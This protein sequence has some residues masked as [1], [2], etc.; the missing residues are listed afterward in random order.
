MSCVGVSAAVA[1]AVARFDSGLVGAAAATAVASPTPDIVLT[2]V[3]DNV[4]HCSTVCIRQHSASR[5]STAAA[6]AETSPTP[7]IDL[8]A[9][10][11]QQRR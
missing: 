4:S 2:L 3:A 7:D 11:G 5:Y 9:M 10:G 1:T 6:K 8:P